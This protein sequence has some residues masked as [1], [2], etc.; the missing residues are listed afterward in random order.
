[1]NILGLVFLCLAGVACLAD[2]PVLFRAGVRSIAVA[3]D[4][5]TVYFPEAHSFLR[6][7]RLEDGAWSAPETLPF[8]RDF[9]Q[10]DPFFSPD[11]TRLFFWSNR[12]RT[13]EAA[14]PND[15]WVSRRGPGGWGEPRC[16]DI[17]ILGKHGGFAFPSVTATGDLY[18]TAR[19]GSLGKRDIFRARRDG[20]GFATPENLG[21]PVNTAADEFDAAISADGNRLVFARGLEGPGCALFLSQYAGGTWGAPRQ[22]GPGVNSGRGAYCPA[23]SPDGR[24]FYF[25]S[26]GGKDREPGIYR[27]AAEALDAPGGRAVPFAPGGVARPNAFGVTFSPDGKTACFAE[28]HRLIME[29]RLVAGAWTR[30]E[31]VPFAREGYH[32][33]VTLAPDGSTLYY[34]SIQAAPGKALRSVSDAAMLA[35]RKGPEGWGKPEWLGNLLDDNLDSFIDS[36]SIATDGTLY[37]TG[38]KGNLTPNALMYAAKPSGKGFG[39]GI[40]LAALNLPD[41]DQAELA[42]SADGNTLVFSS[43][44]PGGEGGT[45]LYLSRRSADGSWSNPRNLGP[46]INTKGTEASPVLGPDGRT[47]YFFSTRD[48]RPGIYRTLLS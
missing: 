5:A 8:S 41:Q 19:R 9:E 21:P 48:G 23:W 45:D 27:I 28:A 24:W 18:F 46:G 1:M 47:L 12:P 34:V 43:N 10:G 25:T 3:P 36:P 26:N 30:P 7:S 29:S 39:P 37:F 20:D 2:G 44:R 6:I 4:G 15:L 42:V 40:P 17:T 31:P 16:L 38:S 33:A 22:L 32:M 13:G 35:V 14:G 11:G